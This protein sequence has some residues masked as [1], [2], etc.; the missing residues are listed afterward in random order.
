MAMG[1][2]VAAGIGYAIGVLTAPKSGKETRKDIQLAA[3]KA[4]MNAEKNLKGLYGELTELI[5]SGKMLAKSTKNSAKTDL[6][7]ALAKAQVAKDKARTVL[8]AF[9]EG[10]AD[11]EDLQVAVKEAKLALTHL[12]KYL[13]KDKEAASTP[14]PAE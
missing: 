12:R 14:T 9:R 13:D 10:D 8:S 7:A 6:T 5:A 2:L 1:A 4:R 11:D 3:Q